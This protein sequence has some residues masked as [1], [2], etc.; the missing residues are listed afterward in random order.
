MGSRAGARR[1]RP[2]RSRTPGVADSRRVAGV[3]RVRRTPEPPPPDSG[4]V[5]RSRRSPP[6]SRNPESG[7]GNGIRRRIRRISATGPAA[8]S[9]QVAIRSTRT[10]LSDSR[11]SLSLSHWSLS[12]SRRVA[13]IKPNY[14]NLRSDRDHLPNLIKFAA[15]I[16][17]RRRIEPNCHKL[18]SR[19]LKTRKSVSYLS[20]KSIASKLQGSK[21][22]QMIR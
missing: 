19:T 5:R 11:R 13:R 1:P 3:R 20:L 4:G 17:R 22:N 9:T 21:I 14:P 8:R 2:G 15:A 10:R 18:S 7:I 16:D 6:E 12:L